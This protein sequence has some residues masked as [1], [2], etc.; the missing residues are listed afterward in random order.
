MGRGGYNMLIDINDGFTLTS[1]ST[2][3]SHSSLFP[4]SPL[5][6]LLFHPPFPLLSSLRSSA[7]LIPLPS[8]SLP[9]HPIN[10]F[11]NGLQHLKHLI[12][13]LTTHLTSDHLILLLIRFLQTIIFKFKFTN[14]NRLID[15]CDAFGG[16]LHVHSPLELFQ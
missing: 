16:S 11:L 3:P 4:Y 13:S 12:H 10:M 2:S 14:D 7:I 5:F 15:L 6:F 9:R 1:P 8:T